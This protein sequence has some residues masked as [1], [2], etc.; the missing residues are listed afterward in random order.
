MTTPF[1][2][3]VRLWH[4]RLTATQ[5]ILRHLTGNTE[6]QFLSLGGRLQDFSLR[7]ADISATAHQLVELV[8]GNDSNELVERLRV[9]FSDMQQYLS[10]VSQQGVSSCTTL[11]KILEQL[12]NVV[13]PLEGFRKMDKALRMLSISTK[14]ESSRLGELGAGFITLAMDVE[15]LSQAV[16]EKSAGIMN[17]RQ[18]LSLLINSNLTMVRTTEADQYTNAQRILKTVGDNLESLEHLNQACSATGN[19]VSDISEQVAA[20]IGTVVSSMQFHDI[21]RQQI[22]HVIEALEKLMQHTCTSQEVKEEACSTLI[23]E[24]GD[25]CELQSAQLRHAADQLNNATRTILES[26]QD[27]AAKQAQITC[28]LQHALMGNSSSTDNSLLHDMEQRMHEVTKILQRCDQ[29]DQELAGSMQSIAVTIAEIGGFVSDIEAVGSEIDLIAL[30]AQIKAAHTGEQGAAL[31]VLAEAIK[32]LSL[33]AV[34]QTEAV[35]KTLQTINTVTA[36]MAE[37]PGQTETESPLQVGTMEQEARHV[38]SSLTSINARLLQQLANL[39]RSSETLADDI[40][41]TIST[42]HV[43]EDVHQKTVQAVH[44][45]EEIFGEARTHVPASPEFRNN[46]VH[47]EERYTMESERMIH[48]M[49]AARHGVKLSLQKQQTASDSGSE[50]GDNV[51]LF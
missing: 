41:A 15:K 21:C 14:I 6:E 13:Q 23:A 16:S 19:Q 3:Q 22:E 50:Y 51:D 7:S 47:M 10:S 24:V 35:S 45:L 28:D 29:A 25:V 9:L 39:V 34:V 27:I 44:M 12:D 49:L 8:A 43:H 46:L 5:E 31:G 18:S 38:I 26:L 32:R 20:D 33:E 2:S 4:E 36:D 48:E 17:Q 11:E 30:N 40:S 42:V 1:C 37:Q